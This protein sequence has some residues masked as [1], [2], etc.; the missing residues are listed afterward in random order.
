MLDLVGLALSYYSFLLKRKPS[1]NIYVRL[2]ASGFRHL[3]KI[4]MSNIKS[5]FR[6]AEY[7]A[8]RKKLYKKLSWRAN[9]AKIKT[10]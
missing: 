4:Y 10:S 6:K 5:R 8:K 2:S 7:N 3:I 9:S 1:S